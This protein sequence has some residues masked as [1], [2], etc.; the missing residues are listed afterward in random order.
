MPFQ[1]TSLIS[2]F[3]NISKGEYPVP[4]ALAA[5]TALASLVDGLLMRDETQRLGVGEARTPRTLE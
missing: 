3:D 2:L 1:G 5:N 4:A